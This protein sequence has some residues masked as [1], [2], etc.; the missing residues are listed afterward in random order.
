L[1]IYVYLRKRTKHQGLTTEEE[2]VG[3]YWSLWQQ[4]RFPY[5]ELTAGHEVILLDHWRDED[6]LSWVLAVTDVEHLHV[7]SKADAVAR[8]AGKFGLNQEDVAD[9]PYLGAK[10][11]GAGYLLTWRAEAIE[12]LNLPRPTGLKLARHGWGRYTEAE[13]GEY[14][15]E[16]AALRTPLPPDLAE[17]EPPKPKRT[18]RK[19]TLQ[20]VP[21]AVEA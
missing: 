18:K 11:E 8:I 3:P 17:A 1:P 6:R 9:D 10:E 15:E 20:P 5:G 14:M 16:A 7:E 12:R 13:I 21:E 19:T 4:R 2:L